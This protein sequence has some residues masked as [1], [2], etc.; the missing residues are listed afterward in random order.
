MMNDYLKEGLLGLL[1]YLVIMGL[2]GGLLVVFFLFVVGPCV[3][4]GAEVVSA[5]KPST[6]VRV[7]WN[8]SSGSSKTMVIHNE[9]KR[10]LKMR[11]DYVEKGIIWNSNKSVNF[12]I[13]GNSRVTITRDFK[14][15]EPF[16]ILIDGDT[17]PIKGTVP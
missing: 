11:L 9:Y 7:T 8:S 2:L 16:S 6:F 13:E 5:Y 10:P 17:S 3:K 4:D 12:T 14:Q 15:G 1:G